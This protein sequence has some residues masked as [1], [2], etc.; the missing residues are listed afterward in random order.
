[1]NKSPRQSMAWLHSW[2]GLLMGWL[3]YIVFVFGSIS[4]YRHQIS[5]WM[6]PAFQKVEFN[7]DQALKGALDYLQEHAQD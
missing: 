7:Q 2:V 5:A 4:Y 3:L 1:M 6:Q